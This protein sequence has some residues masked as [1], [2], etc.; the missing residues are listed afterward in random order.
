MSANTKKPGFR[1]SYNS[2]VVLTYA[3]L[4]LVLLAVDWLTQGWFNRN[5]MVCYG[6]PSLLDPMTSG[7]CV[8]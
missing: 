2:P 7:R 3:A 6:H 5:V 1:L 4:C 8:T